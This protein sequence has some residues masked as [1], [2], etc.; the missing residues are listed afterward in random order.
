MKKIVITTFTLGVISLLTFLIITTLQNNQKVIVS[1]N[2]EKKI[3]SIYKKQTSP[4]SVLNTQI[5]EKKS[6][7]DQ[8]QINYNTILIEKTKH[9]GEGSYLGVFECNIKNGKYIDI[10]LKNESNSPVIFKVFQN[11]NNFKYIK[12]KKNSTL[13]RTFELTNLSK[14]I[15]EWKVYVFNETG[16]NMN[17]SIIAGQYN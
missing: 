17:L 8:T 13:T 1:N 6:P 12:V 15:S 9:S 14:K 7:Y 16:N 4:N 3:P 2:S 10:T 11:S 5:I